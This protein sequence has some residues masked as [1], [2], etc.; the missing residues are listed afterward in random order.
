MSS[1][2]VSGEELDPFPQGF[3]AALS[4]EDPSLP[5]DELGAAVGFAGGD[6]VA[7]GVAWQPM[8]REPVGGLPV[9]GPGSSRV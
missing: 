2:H 6:V 3:L 8:V 7:D 1:E 5:V 9:T 4:D